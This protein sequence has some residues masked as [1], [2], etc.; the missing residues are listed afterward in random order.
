MPEPK[1]APALARGAECVLDG[2]AGF[3]VRSGVVKTATVR[4]VCECQSGLG[5][6]LD[7]KRRAIK[8]WARDRRTG[9]TLVAPAHSIHPEAEVFEVAWACPV[10]T[11]NQTRLFDA[12]G[13]SFTEPS[14]A[15]SP[16]SA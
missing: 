9:R 1:R 13:L 3:P 4:S 8:G 5:A 2:L 16:P 12:G 6:E 11:R 10:C 14:R 7:E 15:S